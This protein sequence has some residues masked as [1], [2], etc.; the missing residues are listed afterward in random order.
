MTRHHTTDVG[1]FAREMARFG[2]Q[3]L[4]KLQTI[5]FFHHILRCPD[6]V[7]LS[8]QATRHAWATV[9]EARW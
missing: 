2:K 9:G 4:E 6:Q 3:A 5:G 7:I 1:T 8:V